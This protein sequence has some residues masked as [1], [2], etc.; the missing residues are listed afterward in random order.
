MSQ[1][2][3]RHPMRNARARLARTAAGV[4]EAVLRIMVEA[5][6]QESP[7]GQQP[8][9]KSAIVVYATTS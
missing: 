4:A 8:V 5:A 6:R 3:G 1:F 7:H 9:D 2:E